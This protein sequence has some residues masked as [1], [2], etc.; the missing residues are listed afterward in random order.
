MIR[1]NANTVALFS[2]C[3]FRGTQ[4]A[5]IFT[6]FAVLGG[7]VCKISNSICRGHW[8]NVGTTGFGT[9]SDGAAFEL[10]GVEIINDEP[11]TQ[12]SFRS[13]LVM[14]GVV[15][16]R[17]ALAL[18]PGPNGRAY[19][20]KISD[21]N[22]GTGQ[23][24]GGGLESQHDGFFSQV[25]VSGAAGGAQAGSR[26][27]IGNTFVN[28]RF[29]TG[30]N[31]TI[32]GRYNKLVNCVF[33]GDTTIQGTGISMTNCDFK[34]NLTASSLSEDNFITSSRLTGS[35][36]DNGTDNSAVFI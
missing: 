12:L 16:R 19:R 3:E 7:A 20:T 26:D 28:C 15:V 27:G 9:I 8:A 36:T 22:L 2:N 4:S 29:G 30:G 31:N 1:V 6:G 35:Y 5:A 17:G 24:T 13:D 25:W 14:R 33:D 23:F 32:G 18:R 34:G 10:N 11:N 21:S